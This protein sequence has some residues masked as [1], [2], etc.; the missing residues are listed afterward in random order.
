MFAVVIE[1]AIG[2]HGAGSLSS[3]GNMHIHQICFRDVPFCEPPYIRRASVDVSTKY[4]L[5]LM[6]T[7][8]RDALLHKES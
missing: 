3:V 6:A 2:R 5:Q 1:L 8:G 7:P 4:W